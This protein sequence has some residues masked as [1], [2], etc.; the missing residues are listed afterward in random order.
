MCHQF[1]TQQTLCPE[2]K[3]GEGVMV[4]TPRAQ[5]FIN[6]SLNVDYALRLS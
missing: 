6:S 5:S 1:H 4:G 3:G 2:E